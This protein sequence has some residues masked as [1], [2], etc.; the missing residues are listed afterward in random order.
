[1]ENNTYYK[2]FDALRFPMALL[3]VWEHST[4][5]L[6]TVVHGEKFIP[7]D[8]PGFAY[9]VTMLNGFFL[10][11]LA[12]PMFLF[13]SGF[14][15]FRS[16]T[17]YKNEYYRKIKSRINTLVVPYIVWNVLAIMFLIVRSSFNDRYVLNL[18]ACNLLSAMWLY[19]GGLLSD[20]LAQ[21]IPDGAWNAPFLG[22]LWYIRNLFMM[23]L[24]SPIIYLLLKRWKHSFVIMTGIAWIAAMLWWPNE[25]WQKI[26]ESL[27]F[28][29]WGGYAAHTGTETLEKYSEK[30]KW[31]LISGLIISLMYFVCFWLNRDIAPWMKWINSFV[32]IPALIGITYTYANNNSL[33]LDKTLVQ[34]SLF[35]Y[36][37]H[38]FISPYLVKVFLTVFPV[39][40]YT[41]F[42][43]YFLAIVVSVLVL[44][45]LF[46]LVRQLPGVFQMM[47][48]GKK[49]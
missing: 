44:L 13:I 36:L 32:M 6:G 29:S 12:V 18:D 45:G 48:L 1:M 33:H 34:S 8:Y 11:P 21:E 23:C 28:F 31:L 49:V 24:A 22:P 20:P 46:L 14:L 30:A 9:P 2:A 5:F 42:A 37:A 10:E 16:G 35:I 39:S 43:I 7:M 25:F 27:C 17:L 15:F 40:N 19:R 41:I 26:L 47:L 38:M 3:V 4:S